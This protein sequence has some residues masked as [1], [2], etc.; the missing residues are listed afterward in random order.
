MFIKS[1]EAPIISQ[2]IIV[3]PAFLMG[4]VPVVLNLRAICFHFSCQ[5]CCS[6]GNDT[7]FFTNFFKTSSKL[8][9]QVY[10]KTFSTAQVK[11]GVDKCLQ[12]MLQA[13]SRE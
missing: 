1:C 3:T 9:A 10:N 6:H 8:N 12:T 5:I 4:A 11:T 13:T 7:H 2:T